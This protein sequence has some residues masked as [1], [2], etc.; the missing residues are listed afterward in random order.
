MCCL[1]FLVL[2][3]LNTS[4]ASWHSPYIAPESYSPGPK[5]RKTFICVSAWDHYVS[6][7]LPGS[8]PNLKWIIVTRGTC[9]P[10]V[11]HARATCLLPR[12]K[13]GAP[14]KPQ[15]LNRATSSTGENKDI[16]KLYVGCFLNG[17]NF[18]QRHQYLGKYDTPVNQWLPYPH[19]ISALG[20]R[21]GIFLWKKN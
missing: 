5:S 3:E 17:S 18:L 21:E 10:L 14:S 13:R 12:T 2:A 20:N 4:Q 16:T 8:P 9:S 11:C 1:C 7:A 15:G 19:P 6:L